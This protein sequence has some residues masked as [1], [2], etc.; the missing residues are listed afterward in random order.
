MA[1]NVVCAVE[2]FIIKFHL[3]RSWLKGAYE[4]LWRCAL[5]LLPRCIFKLNTKLK[6]TIFDYRLGKWGA[7]AKIAY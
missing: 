2:G 6:F 3:A 1:F 7:R 4:N 5:K